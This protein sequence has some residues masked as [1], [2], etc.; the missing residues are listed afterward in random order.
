MTRTDPWKREQVERDRQFLVR[1][2]TSAAEGRMRERT[3]KQQLVEALA[4]SREPQ[5]DHPEPEDA[6]DASTQ[7]G[8]WR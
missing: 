3:A 6:D 2:M 4:A 1:K 5:R 7:R 8:V